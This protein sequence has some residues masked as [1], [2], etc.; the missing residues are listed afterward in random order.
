MNLWRLALAGYAEPEP[1]TVLLCLVGCL[2][3]GVHP[4]SQYLVVLHMA[5]G[6]VRSWLV[7][8]ATIYRRA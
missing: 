8:L 6:S 1:S 7:D 5:A 3:R 2:S 4:S